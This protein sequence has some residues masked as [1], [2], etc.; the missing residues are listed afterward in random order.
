M[1]LYSYRCKK[2]GLEI[3]NLSPITNIPE[4][5]KCPECFHKASR[6][7]KPCEIRY[8]KAKVSHVSD[9]KGVV[10]PVTGKLRKMDS[11][12]YARELDALGQESISTREW[13]TDQD[14]KAR[15]QKEDVN[16]AKRKAKKK[17][18]ST[19]GIFSKQNLERKRKEMRNSV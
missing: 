9:C 10:S 3:T 6:V 2:C 16:N 8:G 14:I 4:S 13:E 19:P 12:E 15:R 11:F 7:F 17:I 5:V 1:P 18:L